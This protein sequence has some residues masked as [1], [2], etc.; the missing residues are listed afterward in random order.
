MGLAFVLSVT[1]C[2]GSSADLSSHSQGQPLSRDFCEELVP[3]LDEFEWQ[4]LASDT[5]GEFNNKEEILDAAR[6][7]S[8]FVGEVGR[9]GV[10]LHATESNW[11]LQLHLSA[12]SIVALAESDREHPEEDI[13]IFAKA[14][15]SW[16]KGAR[17]ECVD[18][19][20]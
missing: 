18:W 3:L 14:I 16:F 1:G 8:A 10:D 4:L 7:I 2:A 13:E 15:E 6:A 9:A 11:L 12:R 17:D 20:A 5:S 19:L